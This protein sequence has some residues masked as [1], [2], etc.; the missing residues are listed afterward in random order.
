MPVDWEQLSSYERAAM[1]LENVGGLSNKEIQEAYDKWAEMEFEP[2]AT[3]IIQSE[4]MLQRIAV[5][6]LLKKQGK[7]EHEQERH[8]KQLEAYKENIR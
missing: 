4:S 3:G 7:W 5:E 8:S 6:I 1:I 2:T